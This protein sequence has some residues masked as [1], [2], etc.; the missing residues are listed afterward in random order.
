MKILRQ[1]LFLFL[2]SA[3]P[4][5]AGEPVYA[6]ELMS[7]IIAEVNDDGSISVRTAS[8]AVDIA[9]LE[10]TIP[11]KAARGPRAI[12]DPDAGGEAFAALYREGVPG[13][14]RGF[15]I[16]ADDDGD[17]FIDED[18]ADGRD[19]DGDGHVDEDF[20]ALGEEMVVI[21][22][23]IGD[24]VMH[25]ETY[26]WGYPHL[27]ETLVLAW[28]REGRGGEPENDTVTF[29]L[30][31]GTW[32]EIPVGWETPR[33]VLSGARP[34]AETML[35]AAQ[36]RDGGRWWIGLTVLER[37]SDTGGGSLP[38]IVGGKLMMPW[39]RP[40]PSCAVA[41]LRPTP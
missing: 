7:N 24:R 34:A 14:H 20:A 3:L 9:L 4:A 25:L 26:H 8:P 30:P 18:R 16:K 10:I 29:A 41:R 36:P 35:V 27:R 28:T 37:G 33:L 23:R 1:L 31:T 40:F 6:T 12:I 22:R 39:R 38:T 2:A 5:D 19:N 11:L 17:G 13:G 15:S 32:Q 21:D